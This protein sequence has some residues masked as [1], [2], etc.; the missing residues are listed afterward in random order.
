LTFSS[1][2][3]HFGISFLPSSLFHLLMLLLAISFRILAFRLLLFSSLRHFFP[4]P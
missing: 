2:A 3:L 1:F 4:P